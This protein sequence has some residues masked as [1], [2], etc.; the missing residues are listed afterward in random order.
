LKEWGFPLFRLC[1]AKILAIQIM[2]KKGTAKMAQKK[3]NTVEVV[4]RL[5]K[6]IAD[7]LELMIWDVRFEKEG[8]VWYL[9]VFIDKPDGV[10][11]QD[12]EN[13]SRQLS[14][15]LDEEDPIVQS[16]VLEVSSPGIGRDL[17]KK[18]QFDRFLG[19]EVLVRFYKPVE[20]ERDYVGKLAGFEDGK[21]S[22]LLQ[23][24]LEMEFLMKEAAFVRLYEEIDMG[25]LS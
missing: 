15:V 9:R 6:P 4:T 22:I 11:I 16:Y 12:C 19:A 13:L 17:R 10:S 21:V 7:S 3:N 8:S 1:M 24:D 2:Q 25:G 18:E 20:G 5:V 23:E 14:P